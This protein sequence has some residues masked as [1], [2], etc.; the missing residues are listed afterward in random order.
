MSQHPLTTRIMELV[1]ADPR[2]L[3]RIAK[4]AGVNPALFF[5]WRN[6]KHTPRVVIVEA[7]LEVLGYELAVVR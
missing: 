4:L 6:G 5:E 1:D 3:C 2:P 7:V